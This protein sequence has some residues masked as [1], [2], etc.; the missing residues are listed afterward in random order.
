MTNRRYISAPQFIPRE[1]G[2]EGGRRECDTTQDRYACRCEQTEHQTLIKCDLRGLFGHISIWVKVI[3]IQ[4][5]RFA[6]CEQRTKRQQSLWNLLVGF[7]QNVHQT[8]SMPLVFLSEECVCS[9][10]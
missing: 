6:F 2:R 5:R 7:F 10:F 8:S 4:A 1:R 9:A 3:T